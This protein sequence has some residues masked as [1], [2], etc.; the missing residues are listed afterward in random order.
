MVL[1]HGFALQVV[2]RPVW[3]G[4]IA[5]IH[6]RHLA[7]VATQAAPG[8]RPQYLT[9]AILLEQIREQLAVRARPMIDQHHL[10]AGDQF[11]WLDVHGAVAVA[12][13]GN[14][15]PAQAFNQIICHRAATIP[16]HIDDQRL[17][18]QLRIELT[19]ELLKAPFPHISQVDITHA[20]AGLALYHVAVVLYPAPLAQADLAA[21]RLDA[22]LA[23]R[24]VR[25]IGNHQL[26]RFGWTEHL[27]KR[28]GHH[29]RAQFGAIDGQYVI[30]S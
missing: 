17:F 5:T 11:L 14:R 1:H 20:P 29:R 7:I 26:N 13:E 9:Q 15:Y 16:A 4:D 19:R 18:V 27:Q 28:I 21:Y 10:G 25:G 23:V 22:H 24:A 2:D 12:V 3:N 6:Q 30:A 8:T